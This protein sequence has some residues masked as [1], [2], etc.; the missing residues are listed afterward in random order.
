MERLVCSLQ[1]QLPARLR[2]AAALISAAVDEGNAA[3][4]A[5]FACSHPLRL[6]R[7]KMCFQARLHPSSS[8]KYCSGGG[9]GLSEF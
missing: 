7:S 1:A 8:P 2:P 3:S 6:S 4:R 9:G 5:A